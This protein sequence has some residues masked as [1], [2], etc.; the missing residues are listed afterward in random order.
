MKKYL[1]KYKNQIGGVKEEE[2]LVK[3]SIIQN[4]S[5][6][7]A[8]LSMGDPIISPVFSP[9]SSYF[10]KKGT[11]GLVFYGIDG[12]L[13]A[14]H[15]SGSR[16]SCFTFSHDGKYLIYCNVT[17]IVI[18]DV[19][20][21]SNDIKISKE[22]KN[23]FDAIDPYDHDNIITSVI[24][25]P[26]NMRNLFVN[27]NGAIYELSDVFDSKFTIRRL[28]YITKLIP[29]GKFI[30]SSGLD[31]LVIWNETNLVIYG[32]TRGNFFGEIIASD[33]NR[34][35]RFLDVKFT[36]RGAGLPGRILILLFGELYIHNILT[37]SLVKSTRQFY[38]NESTISDDGHLLAL[39][40]MSGK[41]I[42]GDANYVLKI[43]TLHLL[44]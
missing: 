31:Y 38:A 8:G 22:I 21:I 18:L 26:M 27:N 16:I 6:V 39:W 19:T 35:S 28:D 30:T 5:Y 17:S 40:A 23:P 42:T 9:D 24:Q 20:N 29:K 44:I 13:L 4:A 11:R 33:L 34:V 25:N 15:N 41:D 7:D 37:N 1:K 3:T 12:K 2:M 43:S 14:T 32:L 36:P 10:V